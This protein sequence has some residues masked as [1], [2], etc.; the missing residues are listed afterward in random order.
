[1]YRKLGKY[2]LCRSVRRKIETEEAL[3]SENKVFSL[4]MIQC[5]SESMFELYDITEER[6]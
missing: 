3:V 5:V 6:H 1:M 4:D 2:G